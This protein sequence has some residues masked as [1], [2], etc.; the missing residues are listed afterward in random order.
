MN[1][2]SELACLLVPLHIVG[3]KQLTSVPDLELNIENCKVVFIV[4]FK[5][6]QQI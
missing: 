2:H 3:L 4:R 6:F 5:K 1:I